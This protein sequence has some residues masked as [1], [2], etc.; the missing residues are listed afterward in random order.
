MYICD[1]NPFLYLHFIVSIAA[2]TMKAKKSSQQIGRRPKASRED[3]EEDEED[4]FG[5]IKSNP[6]GDIQISLDNSVLKKKTSADNDESKE[7]KVP[8]E[9]W[10]RVSD[11]RGLPEQD[12]TVLVKSRKTLK[13]ELTSY[14]R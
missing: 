11:P 7:V 2:F 8:D 4:E 13:D 14:L 6:D 5:L 3:D 9:I 12:A 10:K 1:L